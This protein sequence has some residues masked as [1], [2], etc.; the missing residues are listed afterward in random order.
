M[1][2][3]SRI[4]ELG[5]FTKAADDL[6]LP[7]ATVTHAMQQLEKRLG[8]RLL[9]RTT[10]Q[11][12]PTHD[13]SAYYERCVHLL[14]DL[15]EADSAFS[16]TM[17]KPK[18][19]LRVDLP[20]VLGKYFVLPKIGEFFERYPDVELE[21]GLSD[22]FVDL[23]R[24]RVDCVLRVGEL[25]DSSMVARKVA[26]LE[27]VTCA[28]AV[29]LDKYGTP[30]TLE[31]F[32]QHRAVNFISSITGR[33]APFD[34]MV[35]GIEQSVHLDGFVSVS[36]AEAYQV[37]CNAGLGFV[38]KPRYHVEA[39]LKSGVLREVLPEFRPKPMTV[40]VMYPHQRQLSPRVRVFIDW[41]AD[42]MS[43]AR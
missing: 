3:F 39:D 13:G 29:Y 34:F 21:I 17:A 36:D 14:A 12:S 2:L 10:R 1:R 23:V 35:D 6:Q 33:A 22:R 4:V 18:G 42:V 30:T 31:E 27:Q 24:E 38:Q 15:E 8:T 41:L 9:H 7:R 5:S 26:Q 32:R 37:C 20:G 40:S 28:S 25:R 16:T 19:K 11:V 43:K